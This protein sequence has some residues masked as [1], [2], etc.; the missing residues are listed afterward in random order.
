TGPSGGTI[1]LPLAGYIW[2]S[3][4]YEDNE[5]AD[6]WTST[7]DESNSNYAISFGYHPPSDITFDGD[8]R[9]TGLSVRPVFQVS[10]QSEGNTA[11]SQP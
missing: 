3:E 1:S 7:V 11:N 5:Y 9:Y 4:V 10:N 6:Y 2:G 8:Y